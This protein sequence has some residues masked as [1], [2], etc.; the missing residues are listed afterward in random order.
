MNSQWKER[1]I[2]CG[3]ESQTKE[4]IDPLCIHCYLWEEDGQ[5]AA[6]LSTIP[7]TLGSGFTGSHCRTLM[8][9]HLPKPY[10][11]DVTCEDTF[12]SYIFHWWPRF[13][14]VLSENNRTECN[15]NLC[16]FGKECAKLCSKDLYGHIAGLPSSFKYLGASGSVCICQP[17]FT[18]RSLA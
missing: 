16:Q 13:T 2:K 1:K 8:S 5:N 7:P 9:L 17:G 14:D 12:D 15:S 10:H 11:N 18:D 4:E 3:L 6:M